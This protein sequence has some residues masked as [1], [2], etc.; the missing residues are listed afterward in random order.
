ML[1]IIDNAGAVEVDTSVVPLSGISKDV[2]RRE[3][4]EAQIVDLLRAEAAARDSAMITYEQLGK[5]EEAQRLRLELDVFARYL[6]DV[7]PDQQS[8]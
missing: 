6:E 1:S 2:P 8:L 5:H 3:L 7:T 4:S